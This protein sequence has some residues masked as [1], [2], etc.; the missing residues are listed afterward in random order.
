M[1]LLSSQRFFTKFTIFL[2]ALFFCQGA[3]TSEDLRDRHSHQRPRTQVSNFD[4][5]LQEAVKIFYVAATVST[6]MY[7][8]QIEQLLFHKYG[9]PDILKGS[10]M[11]S[12]SAALLF[13]INR[14]IFVS[15]CGSL[16]LETLKLLASN[17]ID[18]V[19]LKYFH[20]LV[21]H[22][23]PVVWM[24]LQNETSLPAPLKIAMPL[25]IASNLNKGT[26]DND[27]PLKRMAQRKNILPNSHRELGAFALT[28]VAAISKGLLIQTMYDD[29]LKPSFVDENIRFLT[30]MAAGA[31]S[32]LFTLGFEGDNFLHFYKFLK[33]NLRYS[34]THLLLSTIQSMALMSYYAGYYGVSLELLRG[35]LLMGASI[36][37]LESITETLSV[38]YQVDNYI[39]PGIKKGYNWFRNSVLF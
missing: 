9:L 34:Q 4:K 37:C 32:T 15:R 30:S 38:N 29:F 18:Y 10:H 39:I 13:S 21:N 19:V 26:Q 1:K 27:C 31:V 33:D 22:V 6:S 5:N 7:S 17:P 25:L 16:H 28:G 2:I 20:A 11:A 24:S 8:E 3:F 23:F 12:V 36:Y 35:S 14:P